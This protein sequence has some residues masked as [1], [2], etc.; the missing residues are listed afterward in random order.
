M[1]LLAVIRYISHWINCI[2]KNFG[3][4]EM[5]FK[6]YR[7]WFNN[8][9]SLELTEEKLWLFGQI[10][11]QIQSFLFDV[12]RILLFGKPFLEIFYYFGI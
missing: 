3:M 8:R 9:I 1:L 10:T 7:Y 2:F 5:M 6:T 12:L 4:I 11:N